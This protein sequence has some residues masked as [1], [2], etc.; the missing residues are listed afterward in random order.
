LYVRKDANIIGVGSSTG[1]SAFVSVRPAILAVVDGSLVL[2][3]LDQGHWVIVGGDETNCSQILQR[4]LPEESF[5]DRFLKATLNI[6]LAMAARRAGRGATFVLVPADRQGGIE[7]VS[8]A[9]KDFPALPQALD[10]WRGARRATPSEENEQ[11]RILVG[12]SLRLSRRLEPVSMVQ[13]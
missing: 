11:I 12:I 9:A 3:V 7:S 10:A 4:T 2:G 5:P 8:Y 13:R 1:P 6:R